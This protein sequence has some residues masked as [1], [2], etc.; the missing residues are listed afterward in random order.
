MCRPSGAEFLTTS[1]SAY[2]LGYVMPRLSALEVLPSL[3]D[4]Y[5]STMQKALSALVII[6]ASA[7][8]QQ[9]Q[10]S[11]PDFKDYAVQRVYSGHPAAPKLSKA[12]LMYRTRIREGAKSKVEFAGHY[13]V[14]V[15]GCGTG[16]AVFAIVDSITGA[17]YDGFSVADLPL[18]WV[19]KHEEQPRMEFHPES[20]L[21]KING[22]PNEENCGFYDYVMTKDKGL[23][24]VRK[25]LL[26][27]EF[28]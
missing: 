16:C 13:T 5:H 28:Q 2:A 27:K 24:L 10:N 15:W 20:R 1:P 14:P 12:Q 21:F 7:W 6:I 8:A 22:C 4:I 19:E 26:P 25:E 17:V 3:P 11:R 23:K 9:H 18:A